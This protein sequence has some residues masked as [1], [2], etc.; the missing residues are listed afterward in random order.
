MII[1]KLTIKSIDHIIDLQK[2]SIQNGDD[3]ISSSIEVYQRAFQFQ[4]FVFGISSDEDEL[5]AFCNC[6]IP[7]AASKI[8][9]GRGIID[10][11]YLNNV[12]HINTIIVERSWR[13]KGRGK[14]LIQ[15]V[16][17]EF[18]QKGIRHIFVIVSPNNQASL[19]LFQSMGFCIIKNFLYK[20][21]SRNLLQLNL[22][23]I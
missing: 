10:E 11:E 16:L 7:T 3:F 14:K 5:L 12:G 23:S 22:M 6:S 15:T 20:G 2:R 13:K 9:L 17:N 8:N 18:T 19:L 4:N 1:K 21:Y